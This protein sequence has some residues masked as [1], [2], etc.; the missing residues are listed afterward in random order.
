MI[1]LDA[2]VALKWFVKDEPLVEEVLA[3]LTDI[4]RDP[5]SYGVPEFFM[6]EP[7]AVLV[8]M[9]DA[10]PEQIQEAIAL[11]ES[12][13]L[14]RLGNG[15]QLLELTI[16]FAL[17]WGLSGYDAVYVALATASGSR[18]TSRPLRRSMIASLENSRQVVITRP[19]ADNLR[20]HYVKT[21]ELIFIHLRNGIVRQKNWR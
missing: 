1:V 5:R 17:Q 9:K 4:E 11:V 6:N 18:R 13:G 16:E 2:S 21:S 15:H 12:L 3:V 20:A 19:V 10:S 7:V 14:A 8:R